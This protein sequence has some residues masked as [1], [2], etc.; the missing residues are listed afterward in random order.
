MQ[1]KKYILAIILIFNFYNIN[2]QFTK[3]HEFDGNTGGSN[4]CQNIISDGTY[5]YG[6]TGFGGTHNKGCI[7]KIKLDGTDFMNILNFDES[8]NGANPIGTLF[9]DGTYLYGMTVGGGSSSLGLIFK[10][11]PDGTNFS[12]ILEFNGIN[13]GS[14]P[15]GNLIYD[16]TFLFGMTHTGGLYDKGIIFKIKPDGSNF[17]KLLDFQ[18]T[19]NGSFPKG[20]L[21]T[22]GN[23]LYGM[24]VGGGTSNYGTVFKILK[25]GSGFTKIVDFTGL[26]GKSPNEDLLINGNYLYGMT[27]NGGLYDKGIM[28][29]IK[30]DSNTFTKIIDFQ[31]GLYGSL[32]EGSLVTDGT[33]FYGLTTAGGVLNNNGI[34]F[35]I[36]PDGSNNSELVEFNGVNG[37]SPYGSVLYVGNSLYGVTYEG[38]VLSKGII[39]K[40]TLAPSNLL[41]LDIDNKIFVF[42]NPAN[43]IIQIRNINS[44]K[45]KK[46]YNSVGQLMISTFNNDIDISQYGAGI[47]YLQI[48]HKYTKIVIE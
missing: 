38:G 12:I 9:Y 33:Y 48:D 25:D 22:D 18:G 44:N 6:M 19:T 11:L 21:V 2:A 34:L 20:S 5:I 47:Y 40:Y 30:I 23:F 8:T 28:F 45:L 1:F 17:N 31:N 13:K 43:N 4:P 36:M 7:Y 37:F 41:D 26:N 42:P 14:I 46:I 39:F 10:I 29:K 15:F 35:K 32:P 3:I 27:K 16:G 24:T